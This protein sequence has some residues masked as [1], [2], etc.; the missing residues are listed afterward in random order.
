M[1]LNFPPLLHTIQAFC[2]CTLRFRRSSVHIGLRFFPTD[3]LESEPGILINCPA[4]WH[5]VFFRHVQRESVIKVE[6]SMVLQLLTPLLSKSEK[7]T[8]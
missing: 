1:E 6:F 8:F 2:G 5:V 4:V 7:D 3:V